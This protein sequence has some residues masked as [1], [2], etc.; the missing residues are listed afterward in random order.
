VSQVIQSHN[1]GCIYTVGNSSPLAN[2]YG[3]GGIPSVLSSFSGANGAAPVGDLVTD[4]H[5]LYG[6]TSYG[7]ASYDPSNPYVYSGDGTIFSVPTTGGSPNVLASFNGSNGQTPLAGLIISGNMLYGTTSAGGLYGDGVVFSLPVTGGTPT[8]LTSFNGSDGASP[9]GALLLSGDTLY[10][11]TQV[12]GASN[13]GVVFSLPVTGGTPSVLGNFNDANG[14]YPVGTIVQDSSGNIYGVTTNGG[15]NEY[16]TVFMVSQTSPAQTT[17]ATISQPITSSAVT[18]GTPSTPGAV[19][20]S[21][22]SSSDIAGTLTVISGVDSASDLGNSNNAYGAGSINFGLPA[23]GSVVQ[24]WDII[25]SA[26]EPGSSVTLTLTFDPTGMTPDQIAGLY[27]EHYVNGTWDEIPNQDCT[28]SAA[29]DTITFTTTSFSPFALAEVP[30]PASLS[31]LA[32]SGIILLR[33]RSTRQ[34]IA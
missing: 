21:F 28:I 27:I 10:G 16:G 23:D 9:N 17:P 26:G 2:S 13:L 6:V 30:E 1:F 4:G 24:V 22:S 8:V 7:G 32:I 20:A 25:D 31:L 19:Q 29:N 11:T 14:A 15:H 3:T 34:S 12:G 5:S 33:R 18:V